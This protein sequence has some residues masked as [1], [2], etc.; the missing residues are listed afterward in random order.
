MKTINEELRVMDFPCETCSGVG[1]IDGRLGGEWFSNPVSPCPDCDG[2]GLIL[3]NRTNLQRRVE[4]A[5]KKQLEQENKDL[6]E[7]LYSERQNY[8]Q[9]RQKER[10]RFSKF[11]QEKSKVKQVLKKCNDGFECLQVIEIE[12]STN[13]FNIIVA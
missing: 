8:A 13:G 6:R 7:M 9:E 10:V 11:L 2:T 3:A 4:M 5:T 12:Q 1:T